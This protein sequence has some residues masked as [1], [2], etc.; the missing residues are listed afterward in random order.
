[1]TQTKLRYCSIDSYKAGENGHPQ[2]VMKDLLRGV[3]AEV[4]AE[5][6]PIGD[7]WLFWI[8]HDQQLPPLPGFIQE[9]SWDEPLRKAMKR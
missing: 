8:E 7:A 5:P 3:D 1:M 6:I 4:W 9:V 2:T